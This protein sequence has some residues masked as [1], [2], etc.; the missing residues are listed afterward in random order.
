MFFVV[1]IEQMKILY[2]AP[3]RLLTDENGY[4]AD[5]LFVL[6]FDVLLYSP[7][8]IDIYLLLLTV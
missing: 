6:L 3:L 2:H 5:A 7:V 4:I 8:M 1:L